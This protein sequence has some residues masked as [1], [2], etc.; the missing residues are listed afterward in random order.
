VNTPATVD[1]G[2]ILANIRS[3]L[4]LY[5]IPAFIVEKV[6]PLIFGKLGKPPFGAKGDTFKAINMLCPLNELLR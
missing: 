2:T 4:S 3:V 1:P 6:T 5:F